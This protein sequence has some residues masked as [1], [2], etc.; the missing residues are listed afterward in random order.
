M[1]LRTIEEVLN[2]KNNVEADN[3]ASRRF[4]VKK[5]GMGYSLSE[6]TIY[7]GS[8]TEIWYKNHFEACYCVEGEGCVPRRTCG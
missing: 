2:S 3:W 1:I 7:A 5:D 4:L 6:T 8:E